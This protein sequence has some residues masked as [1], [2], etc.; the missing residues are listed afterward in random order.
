MSASIVALGHVG[1]RKEESFASGGDPTDYQPI[2]SED[3]RMEKHYDYSDRIMNTSQQVG[4]RLLNVGITGSITFPISPDGPEMWWNCGLGQTSYIY[5]EERPLDSMVIT[6]DRE[7]GDIYTSGDMISSL[8]ISSAAGAPLQCVASIEG[9]GYSDYTASTPSY[10]SG[11][12]G[13][14]HNEGKFYVAGAEILNVMTFSVSIN[15]NLVTDLYTNQKERRDIPAT[16]CMVTG[17]MTL[18]FEDTTQRNR[19]MTEES[20]KLEAV[21]A[22]GANSFTVTLDKVR[23]DDD[24]QPLSGQTDYIAETINFT[25]YVDDPSTEESIQITVV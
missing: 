13:F 16:K 6:L 25:A 7:A 17:N 14:L 24:S 11:D 22:R 9:K 12:D 5:S 3:I 18:L 4:G 10:T 19:F 1:I 23:F 15:N 2:F 20:V 21:Y 8:E